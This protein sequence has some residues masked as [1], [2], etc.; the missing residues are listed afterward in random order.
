MNKAKKLIL[1]I[2][3]L[4]AV[5]TGC[6]RKTASGFILPSDKFIENAFSEE[7]GQIC[8][9]YSDKGKYSVIDHEEY[10][11][12]INSESGLDD[13]A[14]RKI[15]EYKHVFIL[16]G[17]CMYED[18]TPDYPL[19]AKKAFTETVKI[20]ADDKDLYD[21]I[22]SGNV[23]DIEIGYRI[24]RDR[25]SVFSFYYGSEQDDRN[26]IIN[27]EYFSPYDD[28]IAFI[29][30]TPVPKDTKSIYISTYDKEYSQWYDGNEAENYESAIYE[31]TDI[32]GDC[33]ID[34]G[35]IAENFPD[36][37]KLYLSNRLVFTDIADLSEL[38]RLSELH[39]D[40]LMDT[41]P[42]PMIEYLSAD[43]LYLSGITTA[44]DCLAQADADELILECS[45]NREVLESIFALPNVSELKI[46][47]NWSN[48][49]PD[50][51]GIGSMT[52]LKR[53]SVS[54]EGGAVD[55]APLADMALEE[56]SVTA[57]QTE[58]LGKIADI[59]GLK[60]LSLYETGDEDLSFISECVS[61]ERLCVEGGNGSFLSALP[62]LTSLKVLTAE[63]DISDG[64]TEN[65][66]LAESLE[67]L[68]FKD[69]QADMKNISNLKKLKSL[70]LIDCYYS[71]LN[72]LKECSELKELY[73]D[74]AGAGTFDAEIIEEISGLEALYLSDAEFY[75][76]KSLKALKNLKTLTLI[77]CDLTEEQI[78]DL[79]SDMS[80]CEINAENLNENTEEQDETENHAE[81]LET[82]YLNDLRIESYNTFS[83]FWTKQYIIKN[84]GNTT[85][86]N[87][88]DFLSENKLF[89]GYA[90][91]YVIYDGGDDYSYVAEIMDINEGVPDYDNAEVFLPALSSVS[92][93]SLSDG[94][95]RR[96]APESQITLYLSENRK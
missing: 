44:A 29:G 76:Y 41:D 90:A 45:C 23:R 42:A 54:A 35:R 93:N 82:V 74:C 13:E 80:Y 81:P 57:E 40:L 1:I 77:S 43:K 73:I 78:S 58:N 95:Y 96:L 9:A 39:I 16:K 34:I 25:I 61:L 18:D 11:Q 85:V 6:T 94:G 37:E 28:N 55:L 49:V 75:H 3:L 84:K 66:Y 64:E 65:I 88:T 63:G 47:P 79:R 12:K 17:I 53:L 62:Y 52:G 91:L 7:S 10:T 71:G 48:D 33:C 19:C 8:I 38:G 2:M 89:D 51:K 14:V 4:A 21:A 26:F 67:E 68:T 72:K 5:L 92:D 24:E 60:S 69:T 15:S 32:N 36:L 30:Q 22:I 20:L 27:G 86:E 56:L 59:E 70:T 87:I 31:Y 46:Q 50:L 83:E